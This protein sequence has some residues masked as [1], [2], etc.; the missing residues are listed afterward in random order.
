[1]PV[2]AEETT[3]DNTTVE[4]SV[5]ETTVEET[6]TETAIDNPDKIEDEATVD[7]FIDKISTSTLWINVVAIAGSALAVIGMVSKKFGTIIALVKSK[8][9]A[10]TIKKEL[11]TSLKETFEKFY[12][13]FVSI[14]DRLE[15]SESNEK[16]LTTALSIFMVNA[17]ISNSAKSE[18]LKYMHGIKTVSGTVS[19]EIENAI[20]IIEKAEAEEEKPDTTT[21][22]KLTEDNH[23]ALG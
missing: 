17:K 5:E 16:V 2:F 11:D 13:E 15:Q 10:S 9:D 23:I 18:I 7:N 19:E 4:T 22:D 21:L 1:M 6:T 3:V 8:A 20:K 12:K 14:K